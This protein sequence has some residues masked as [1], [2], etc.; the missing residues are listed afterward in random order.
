MYGSV[1]ERLSLPILGS[2][3]LNYFVIYLFET[4]IHYI[5]QAVLEDTL[6]KLPAS[7]SP[8]VAL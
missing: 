2:I 1:S 7:S 8:M 3:F 6:G 4:E 5:T